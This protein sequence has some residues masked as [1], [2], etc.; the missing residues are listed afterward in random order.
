MLRRLSGSGGID[1]CRS[2][3]IQRCADEVDLF[4]CLSAI[5]LV[6]YLAESWIHPVGYTL[7]GST[8][9]P[10]SRLLQFTLLFRKVIPAAA[11]FAFQ[12][13]CSKPLE[14]INAYGFRRRLNNTTP[15]TVGPREEGGAQ[16]SYFQ[17]PFFFLPSCKIGPAAGEWWG[18]SLF[19]P[20]LKESWRHLALKKKEGK[21]EPTPSSTPFFSFDRRYLW[22]CARTRISYLTFIW[23]RSTHSLADIQQRTPTDIHGQQDLVPISFFFSRPRFCSSSKD[24]LHMLI[25]NHINPH[26]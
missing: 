7:E 15:K 25:I 11:A 21:R 3:G 9:F 4:F 12:G 23:T 13:G 2:R 10:F 26:I 18:A 5:R 6:Y 1:G 22:W 19:L 8:F 16:Q 20:T 17:W 24:P 14:W